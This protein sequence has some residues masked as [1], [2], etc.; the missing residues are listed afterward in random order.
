MQNLNLGVYTK[1]SKD[2]LYIMDGT[3]IGTIIA[4]VLPI[5]IIGLLVMALF[6]WIGGKFIAKLAN[7]NYGSALLISLF[8]SLITSIILFILYKIGLLGNIVVYIVL[9][10][11]LSIASLSYITKLYWKCKDFVVALKASSIN[12]ILTIIFWILLLSILSKY[13]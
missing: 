7:A 10:I 13:M 5:Y 6:Q 1:F 11:L 3:I 9:I 8:S 4:I 12:I 2:P